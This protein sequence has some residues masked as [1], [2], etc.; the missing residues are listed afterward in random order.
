M[1]ALSV[2]SCSYKLGIK[3]IIPIPSTANVQYCI[4]SNTDY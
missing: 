1:S 2:D 3:C 4:L